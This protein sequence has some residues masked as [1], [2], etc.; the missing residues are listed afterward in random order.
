MQHDHQHQDPD[1]I[2]TRRM[3]TELTTEPAKLPVIVGSE[4]AV[5]AA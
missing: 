5:Y 2:P 1:Q 3:I 4:L